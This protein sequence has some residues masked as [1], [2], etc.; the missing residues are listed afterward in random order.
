MKYEIQIA[1][2]VEK[3]KGKL[4]ATIYTRISKRILSLSPELGV[5]EIRQTKFDL[6][7]YNE[8]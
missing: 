2:P 3:E 4:P 8:D 7:W 6:S 5:G 1:Q